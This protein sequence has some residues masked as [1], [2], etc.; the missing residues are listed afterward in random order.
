M[1]F[2]KYQKEGPVG[3]I[4][5]D[6]QNALNALNSQVLDELQETLNGIREDQ[7][8]CSLIVTGAGERAFV[9]GA[10]IKE[11]QSLEKSAAVEFARKGQSI[12]T[13][14]ENLKIPSICAVNGFAL[15]GGLEL[16]MSCDFIF[17]S[18]KAKFGLPEVTLGLIPG[19]GGT[20]RLIRFVGAAKAKEIS[21]SGKHYR[22]EEAHR[23]GLVNQVFAPQDLLPEA[24]SIAHA[25]AEQAP[26]AVQ[27]CKRAIHFADTANIEEGQEF[28][29]KSFAELF[30]TKDLQTG[31]Q[32]FI[33][34]KKPSFQGV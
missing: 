14:I 10:D 4:T 8:L 2:V 21:F 26:F 22:A 30:S 13:Q 15:G 12:F 20:Q 6:R 3:Q 7:E 28:E 11:I 9:A 25:I 31:L 17:A 16:A 29:A 33:D 34:K 24:K 32:A 19:F 27:A 5:I 18:E 23:I 1:E